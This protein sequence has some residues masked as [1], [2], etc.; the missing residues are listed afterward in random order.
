MNVSFC[1]KR[2]DVNHCVCLAFL[3]LNAY[4]V[5]TR[6][7]NNRIHSLFHNQINLV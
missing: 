3:V 6:E 2:S 5:K 4:P 7:F 1:E